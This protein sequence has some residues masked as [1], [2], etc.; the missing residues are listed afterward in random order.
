MQKKKKK[1]YECGSPAAA[2]QQEWES[3]H[4]DSSK[5]IEWKQHEYQFQNRLFQEFRQNN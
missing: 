4:R 5:R 2:K 1:R 3:S